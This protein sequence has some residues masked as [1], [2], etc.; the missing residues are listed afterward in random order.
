MSTYR[1][2]RGNQFAAAVAS[3]GRSNGARWPIEILETRH[4]R[5]TLQRT[6]AWKTGSGSLPRAPDTGNRCD[7]STSQ[8]ENNS[9]AS[10]ARD[11]IPYREHYRNFLL[12][13]DPRGDRLLAASVESKV[14]H[15]CWKVARRGKG[16]FPSYRE[17]EKARSGLACPAYC[18]ALGE[19][20]PRA[21]PLRFATSVNDLRF[22]HGSSPH[23]S[24]VGFYRLTTAYP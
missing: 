21:G 12:A 1:I 15:T 2:T 22:E 9:D 3:G 18:A 16:H 19:S 7:P 4:T 24:S 20:D 8:S 23:Y 17:N 6:S 10:E 14:I 13:L 11:G 5:C